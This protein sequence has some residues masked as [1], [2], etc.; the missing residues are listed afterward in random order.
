MAPNARGT[1][2]FIAGGREVP[3]RIVWQRPAGTDGRM[4]TGIEI[5]SN[6][7]FWGLDLAG[8]E[9]EPE[10][11]PPEPPPASAP[12][13]SDSAALVEAVKGQAGAATLPMDLW[14]A[15]VDALEAR[16]VFTREELI[17]MLRRIG[18]S[19]ED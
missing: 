17:A 14:C 11:V 6:T 2:T 10:P 7:N 16:G 18:T 12:A 13:R 5:F 1:A 15:V 4:E 19:S 8:S 9:L 3:C